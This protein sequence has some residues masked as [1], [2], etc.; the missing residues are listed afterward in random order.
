MPWFIPLNRKG[1]L[2]DYMNEK[3]NN[4]IYLKS[5]HRIDTKAVAADLKFALGSSPLLA[6]FAGEYTPKRM[7]CRLDIPRGCLH[8]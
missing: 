2:Q 5:K 6:L 4:Y 3:C 7:Q 1:G 8:S